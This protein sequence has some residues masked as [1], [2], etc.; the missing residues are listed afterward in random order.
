MGHARIRGSR[1]WVTARGHP[2]KSSKVPNVIGAKKIDDHTVDFLLSAHDPILPA[3]WGNWYIMSKAWAEANGIKVNPT[4]EEISRSFAATNANGT[5]PFMFIKR[6]TDTLTEAVP[7]PNWWGT[8]NHDVTKVVFRPIG[9]AA[10][11]TAALIASDIDVAIPVPLQDQAR[12]QENENTVLLA[13]PETRTNFIGFDVGS[14]ELVDSN[15]KGKNPF[16]DRRVRLAVYQ[17]IDAQAIH[18]KVMLGQS[19]VTAALISPTS[20]GFPKHLQRYPFDREASRL[21]LAEAGY[22]DGFDVTL[23]TATRG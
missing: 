21:L 15:V 11:R 4:V 18:E 13:G 19:T 9:S 20:N 8:P 12:V 6:Q 17:A 14:D 23:E 2:A 16:K 7:N 3:S 10:T 5:G 1:G 22:P